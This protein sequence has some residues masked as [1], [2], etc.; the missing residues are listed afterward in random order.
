M[1]VGEHGEVRCRAW[2][3]KVHVLMEFYRLVLV[4]YKT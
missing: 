1:W 4:K 2:S 3:G